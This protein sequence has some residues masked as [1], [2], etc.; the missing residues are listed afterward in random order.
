MNL[1]QESTNWASETQSGRQSRMVQILAVLSQG[2]TVSEK[3]TR[4][5]FSVSGK[6]FQ[7]RSHIIINYYKIMPLKWILFPG[8]K[9]MSIYVSGYIC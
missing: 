3:C 7:K 6:H 1:P 2:G 5:F 4:L 9:K 8:D